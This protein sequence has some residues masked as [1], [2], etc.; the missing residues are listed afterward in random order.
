MIHEGSSSSPRCRLTASGIS[1]A[2]AG[3]VGALCV[4][5]QY[6]NDSG[7]VG[8]ALDCKQDHARPVFLSLFPSG[9]VLMVPEIGIGDDEAWLRVGDRH[10][11]PLFG[12]E[13][14]V[15]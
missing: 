5:R 15:E 6:G 14:L 10:G 1:T 7:S 9:L 12:V 4:I 8:V 3:S 2:A 11:P 13:Q